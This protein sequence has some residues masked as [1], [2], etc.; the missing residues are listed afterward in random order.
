M[1]ERGSARD[2]GRFEYQLERRGARI[3]GHHHARAA[4]TDDT[5]AQAAQTPARACA[6]PTGTAHTGT[7][8]TGAA[9]TGAAH[10]GAAHTGTAYTGTT[11]SDSGADAAHRRAHLRFAHG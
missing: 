11:R 6:A 5:Q 8:H 4:R 2:C 9:P 7:A 10:T 1:L 3:E